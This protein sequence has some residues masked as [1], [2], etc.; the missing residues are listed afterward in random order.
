M[1]PLLLGV[2]GL[3]LLTAS[4]DLCRPWA[5][6]LSQSVVTALWLRAYTSCLNSDEVPEM[7]AD[8][9]AALDRLAP[10]PVVIPSERPGTKPASGPKVAG[11]E[12]AGDTFKE[13]AARHPRGY[14]AKRHTYNIRK[15]RKWVPT[16]CQPDRP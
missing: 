7:P 9:Q 11:E 5:A 1:T 6:T 10:R 15:G 3:A 13:C 8:W 12:V 2:T 14:D 4:P 16:P